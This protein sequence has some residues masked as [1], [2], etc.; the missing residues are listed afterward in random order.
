MANV[1]TAPAVHNLADVVELSGTTVI[2]HGGND[3]IAGASVAG[4][5]F[6]IGRRS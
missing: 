4:K 6:A 3:A 5:F 1:I 2:I